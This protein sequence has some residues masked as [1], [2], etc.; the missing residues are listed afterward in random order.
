[1]GGASGL[2][3][4]GVR[5]YFDIIEVDPDKR[6]EFFAGIRACERSML[7]VWAEQR[8]QDAAEK[9]SGPPIPGR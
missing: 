8:E 3:Y 6:R 7:D 1:M 2:D 4:A 9:P 5:A